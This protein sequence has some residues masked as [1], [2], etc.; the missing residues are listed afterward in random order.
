MSLMFL[1]HVDVFCDLLLN[2]RTATLDLIKKTEKLLQITLF[3]FRIFHQNWNSA[4]AHLSEHTKMPFNVGN[5][6]ELRNLW[7]NSRKVK[8]AFVII[9]A[10]WVEKL[11]CFLKYSV[12]ELKKYPWKSCC[13]G[14]YWR[15]FDSSLKWKDRWWRW[16]FV[17]SVVGDFKSVWYSVGETLKLPYSWPWAIASYTLF[18]AAP[19]TDWKIR[20]RQQ[21]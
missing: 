3:H 13:C 7:E 6:I 9:A 16:K 8:S 1:P 19:E 4:F 17:S 15:P 11:G 5:R 14:Q 2:R 20:I 21:G 18:T 12:Q 10:L